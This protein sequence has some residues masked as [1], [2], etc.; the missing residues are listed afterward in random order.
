M[1]KNLIDTSELLNYVDQ[2]LSSPD[3]APVPRLELH[4]QFTFLQGFKTILDSNPTP[5]DLDEGGVYSS[6]AESLCNDENS[7]IYRFYEYFITSDEYL[8]IDV[9]LFEL[10]HRNGESEGRKEKS[11]F[12]HKDFPLRKKVLAISKEA[13]ASRSEFGLEIEK[14]TNSVEAFVGTYWDRDA[15]S[16]KQLEAAQE[17]HNLLNDAQANLNN[18]RRKIDAVVQPLVLHKARL[19]EDIEPIGLTFEAISHNPFAFRRYRY[20]RQSIELL[21][22]AM[23]SIFE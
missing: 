15:S 23:N 8:W 18:I 3:F 20:H 12:P 2:R 10:A 21:S 19:K 7:Q 16:S 11:F 1:G 4:L 6:A 13:G 22:S 17:F 5:K 9:E 14:L